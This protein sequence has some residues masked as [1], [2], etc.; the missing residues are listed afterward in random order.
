M[1]SIYKSSGIYTYLLSILR[2]GGSGIRE[3]LS[4]MSI[5]GIERVALQ[6]APDVVFIVMVA[7]YD[8]NEHT[9]APYIHVKG[10]VLKIDL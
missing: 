7:L 3:Y 2:V 4:K 10:A 9:A 6:M 1:R 5:R 8:H